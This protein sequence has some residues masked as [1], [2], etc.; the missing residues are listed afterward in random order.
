MKKAETE[1]GLKE[2][3][4]EAIKIDPEAMKK[5]FP[6]DKK[7]IVRVLE[8]YKATGKTKTEQ[9]ILSRA[10]GVKYD[11]KIFGIMRD[12]NELY[13]RINFRVDL[14]IKQ[15][16]VEEVKSIYEKYK[17]FPTAMQGL[18]YKEVIWY[19]ENKITYDEMVDLIKKETRRYAKR[20]MTWFRKTENIIWLDGSDSVE[21]N[22]EII[23]KELGE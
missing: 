5:I 8:I 1:E 10:G 23:M 18:G 17:K 20:Q 11:Y 6:S 12:R 2:L 13:E 19:L 16:L 21:K 9:E 4:E 7:R 22:I 15:G 3:Y 14:M